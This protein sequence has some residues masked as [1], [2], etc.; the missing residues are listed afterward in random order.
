MGEK[1]LEWGPGEG[2]SVIPRTYR[3]SGEGARHPEGLERGCLELGLAHT[4]THTH[5][6]ALSRGASRPDPPG[7]LVQETEALGDRGRGWGHPLPRRRTGL[8]LGPWG[9]HKFLSASYHGQTSS[10]YVRKSRRH[11]QGPKSRHL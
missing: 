1:G 3:A 2:G 5:T 9:T 11:C 6:N 7:R 8:T 10:R 4:H